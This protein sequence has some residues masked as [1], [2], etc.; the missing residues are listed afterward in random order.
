M[1]LCILTGPASPADDQH[2]PGY[3]PPSCSQYSPSPSPALRNTQTATFSLFHIYTQTCWPLLGVCT[4]PQPRTSLCK[5]LCFNRYF[6]KHA[7][8]GFLHTHKLVNQPGHFPLLSFQPWTYSS[9]SSIYTPSYKVQ[10]LPKQRGKSAAFTT[11]QRS[12][13]QH[14]AAS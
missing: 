2:I 6:N 13:S 8:S 11:L 3:P 4:S 1:N 12:F 7:H 10:P 14:E 9:K 5:H